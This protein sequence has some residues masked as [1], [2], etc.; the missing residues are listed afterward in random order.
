MEKTP[1][2]ANGESFV[3]VE[4]VETTWPAPNTTNSPHRSIYANTALTNW[5]TRY[6][7][8]WIQRV[9]YLGSS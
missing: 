9:D 2:L 6:P 5:L 8:E 1:K 7:S 4:V 3:Q